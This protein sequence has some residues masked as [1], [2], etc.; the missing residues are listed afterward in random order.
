MSNMN[1]GEETEYIEINSLYAILFQGHGEFC[2]WSQTNT[3]I[4]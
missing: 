3:K 2:Y 4:V 1:L